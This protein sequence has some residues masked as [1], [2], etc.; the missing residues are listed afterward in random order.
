LNRG[1][2]YRCAG[3]AMLVVGAAACGSTRQSEVPSTGP[4]WERENPIKPPAS[5]PLG[6]EV[7]FEDVKPRAVPHRQQFQR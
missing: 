7:F 1:F 4:A 5:A 2:W 6:M 3:A